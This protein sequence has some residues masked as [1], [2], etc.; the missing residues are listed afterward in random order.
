VELD[1]RLPGQKIVRSIQYVGL[2][3]FCAAIARI[4][5]APAL[6]AA[7]SSAPLVLQAPTL[8]EGPQFAAPTRLDRIGRILAPVMVNGRGPFR[9]VVDTGANYTAITPRLI[10]SLGLSTAPNAQVNLNG[11]TGAELVPTVTLD[12]LETGDILQQAVHVP[13]LGSA[14][15][16]ADGILGM[17][18]F[19]D[20]RITVD[21]VK[22]RI[23]IVQSH[24]ERAPWNF[25]AVP[26]RL[27]FGGL[28]VV[29]ARVGR[30]AAK[31]VIDTGAERTL[32][33]RL[34]R[35]ALAR[36]AH[37]N[38]TAA[39]TMVLGVTSAQ[40]PGDVIQSPPLQLGEATISDVA[41]TYGDFYVFKLWDLE[42]EPA[43]LVGMDVLGVLHTLVID[44]R[45]KELQI[46]PK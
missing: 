6:S 3:M 1:L 14:M 25:I 21:F 30:V 43:I 38:P 12:R 10:E 35:E 17:R 11:V 34:L 8:D 13:V 23:K 31:A 26:A 39:A 4:A 42:K 20:K 27:R 2:V 18:G 40:Q 33:N 32:G 37:H 45:R 7:E 22:D 41:V 5:D 44:Y 36:H 29:D 9:F 19:E 24:G 15:G 46:R 28:M 16:G